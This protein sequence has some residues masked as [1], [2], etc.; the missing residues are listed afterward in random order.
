MSESTRDGATPTRADVQEPPPAPSSPPG[1]PPPADHWHLMHDTPPG[2]QRAVAAQP[3]PA[4][5]PAPADPAT[6]LL[7]DPPATRPGPDPLT[8]AWKHVRG[9]FLP[10]P[11]LRTFSI[12]C[13]ICISVIIAALVGFADALLL[14]SVVVAALIV[15][16]SGS[17]TL[18]ALVP[19]VAALAWAVPGAVA[20]SAIANRA[21]AMP[22]AA[23]SAALRALAMGV[24]AV[25]SAGRA[26]GTA[27]TLLTAF[28]ALYAVA[29]IAG[30]FATLAGERLP[31]RVTTNHAR[32]RFVRFRAIAASVA[33]VGAAFLVRRV[34][35][36][37]EAS[38]PKQ[39][40]FFFFVAF[41]A[42]LSVAV[43]TCFLTERANMVPIAPRP[44][45]GGLRAAPD[46]LRLA[47]Y[48][49]YLF[50]RIVALLA[51]LAEPF[52]IVY[53]L[54]TLHASAAMVGAYVVAITL[55]RVV[56]MYLWR[57]LARVTGTKL[58]LQLGALLRTL[59]A[60][61]V[62]ILP[63]LWD[64]DPLADRFA[65]DAQRARFFLVVFVCIGAAMGANAVAQGGLL[66]DI[67]PPVAYADGVAFTN[68]VLAVCS[69]G[70]VAGGLIAERKGLPT[71]FIVA[72]V[73]GLLTMLIGGILR[74]PRQSLRRSGSLGPGLR[75]TEAFA[76]L[77]P[78]TDAFPTIPPRRGF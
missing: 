17:Y 41:L 71:L 35:T 6:P 61:I 73:A 16:V 46:L 11:T 60:G 50:F 9:Y 75:R 34:L 22:L 74:E 25:V 13:N 20:G 14:P 31:G 77:R 49:R 64:F 56:S 33:A 76:T 53:A 5:N 39:Y 29:N 4:P 3:P 57:T 58:V 55:T 21:R 42:L 67:L 51:T 66:L 68:G 10:R 40:L 37:G 70:L 43:L 2:A 62:I 8:V 23:G 52:F 19:V 26:D 69:V 65:G 12:Y 72:L 63:T 7:P 48:R 27:K 59:A 1:S 47:S 54:R 45:F 38:F 44:A 32:G 28:F 30:G 78:P 36:N 15:R 18:V 24:L